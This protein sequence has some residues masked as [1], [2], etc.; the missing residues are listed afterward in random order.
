[1]QKYHLWWLARVWEVK[2]DGA[3]SS[4]LFDYGNSANFADLDAMLEEFAPHMVGLDIG[5]AARSAEVM[6][7]CA[8]YTD[9]A[10]PLDSVVLALRGSD[11]LK[12]S[13]MDVVV[14]DAFEGRRTGTGQNLY[15]EITWSNDVFR[16]WLIEYMDGPGDTWTV[17][18]CIGSD[19]KGLEYLRQATTTKKV[20]GIWEPPRHR[21]DH[22]FDCEVMQL[23]LAR[24]NQFIN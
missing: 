13:I 5:Y 3:I 15:T 17:P 1:M 14:R 19:K 18:G 24:H 8:D 6:D 23:V 12:K 16:Q 4:H 11:S 7:Y 9:Q 2:K 22:L 20:D 21:Q 10:R